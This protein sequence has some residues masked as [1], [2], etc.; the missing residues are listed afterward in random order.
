ME[1]VRVAPFPSHA[2]LSA[3][4]AL[5]SETC[6]SDHVAVAVDLRVRPDA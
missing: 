3:S 1:V 6:P 4:R 5:P 2:Q